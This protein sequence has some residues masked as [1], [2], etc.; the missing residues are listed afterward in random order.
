MQKKADQMPKF[1][2]GQ[3]RPANAGRKRGSQNLTTR[4][5]RDATIL[6]AAQLG[7]LSGINGLSEA[8]VEQ[9]KDGLVGYLRH[10]GRMYPASFASLLGRLMPMQERVGD[11]DRKRPYRCI[12]SIERDIAARGYSFSHLGQLMIEADAIEVKTTSAATGGGGEVD[13]QDTDDGEKH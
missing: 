10:L 3:K 4:L 9:G 7:D 5:I 12:D 11:A 2:K 6:A 13:K 1:K 8:G